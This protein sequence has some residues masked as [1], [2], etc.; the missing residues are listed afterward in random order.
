MIFDS[1]PN[2]DEVYATV[3]R[4][5]SFAGPLPVPKTDTGSPT[6]RCGT[7]G[8]ATLLVRSWRYFKRG[9]DATVPYRCDVATKCATC[10][11]LTW[12]GVVV[13]PDAWERVP[14][15]FITLTIKRKEAIDKGWLDP[16]PSC[17]DCGEPDLGDA[18]SDEEH[19][20]C[21]GR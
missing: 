16:F 12:F 13:P 11:A 3:R 8:Y 10:S 2:P 4:V 1:T 18:P 21:V 9:G 6:L 19:A 5:W 20:D 15:R 17:P 7:C 14:R